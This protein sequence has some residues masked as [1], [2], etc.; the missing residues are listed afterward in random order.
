MEKN[1]INRTFFRDLLG[2]A[3]AAILVSLPSLFI[4][5][6]PGYMDAEYYYL[7]GINLFHGEG[8]FENVVWN[9][10]NLPDSLPTASHLYWMP[11][12]SILASWGLWLFQSESYVYARLFFIVFS[13]MIPVLTYGFAYQLSRSRAKA[14]TAGFMA[15][16]SGVY[17][18]YLS[19]VETFSPYMLFG[20]L[21]FYMVYL[22]FEHRL[23][24]HPGLFFAGSGI[25]CGLMHLSRADGILWLG[26]ITLVWIYQFIQVK[27][28]KQGLVS[29]GC[30]LAG[31]LLIMLPWY[32][33]NILLFNSLFPPG[34]ENTL[35]LLNY[36]DTFLYPA[37]QIT[38]QRWLDSGWQS[39]LQ[40]RAEAIG[41]NLLTAW[42]IHFGIILLPFFILYVVE[43]RKS[44]FMRWVLLCYLVQ[45]LFMSV[46]FPFAGTRGGFF[47]SGSAFQIYFWVGSAIGLFSAIRR[48]MVRRHQT[49]PRIVG[50]FTTGVLMILLISAITLVQQKVFGT[51]WNKTTWL[52]SY[53]DYKQLD[54]ALKERHIPKDAAVMINNPPG[55]YLASQRLAVVVPNASVEG[56]LALADQYQVTYVIL[57][58]HIVPELASLYQHET[59]VEGLSYLFSAGGF[60]IYRVDP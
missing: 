27:N 42:M 28:W 20:G 39:I 53:L 25:L 50:L 10:L 48:L 19:L 45:F 34:N 33:R 38:L 43:N 13:A 30:L 41:A 54:D 40:V 35:F 49:D 23:K 58:K 8:F 18:V 57:D 16:F 2:L 51:P 21:I 56:V 37:G 59:S 22:F 11:L 12:P 36:N 29:G 4:Q 15:L 6:V 24:L 55:F 46:L 1:Q 60:K 47:H 32:W 26:F 7:G 31:Y 3:M 52:Q 44:G 14:L 17:L 5:M 9:T